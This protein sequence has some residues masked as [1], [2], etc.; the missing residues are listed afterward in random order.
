M[1]KKGERI[2]EFSLADQEGNQRSLGEFLGKGYLVIFF[3]P[4]DETPGCIREA[5]CFRDAYEDFQDCEAEIIGI[6]GDS[7]ES[8][9]NFARKRK[10]PFVLLSDPGYDVHQIFGCQPGALSFLKKR[11]TFIL[12][13]HGRIRYEYSSRL[14]FTQHVKQALGAI[15]QL[16]L[17]DEVNEC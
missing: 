16:K 4:K 3:Y 11:V 1:L 6:S 9:E 17:V 10:L 7:I 5:G 15:R 12:D 13:C 2:K 14:L 8:H